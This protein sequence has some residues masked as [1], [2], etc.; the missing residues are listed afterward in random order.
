[1]FQK[2]I[3]LWS[4]FSLSRTV[5]EGF[6]YFSEALGVGSAA[7]GT[8]AFSVVEAEAGLHMRTAGGRWRGPRGL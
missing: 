7:P 1:M 4:P 8:P 6:C 5:L 2:T 3:P